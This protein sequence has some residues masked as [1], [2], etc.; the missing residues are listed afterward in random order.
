MVVVGTCG[1]NVM[2]ASLRRSHAQVPGWGVVATLVGSVVL[3]A[4]NVKVV[5]VHICV[6]EGGGRVVLSR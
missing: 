3:G 1:A 4:V 2:A 5:V 6:V